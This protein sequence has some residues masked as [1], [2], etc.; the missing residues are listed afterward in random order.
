MLNLLVVNSMRSHS[1][2]A[3]SI[4]LS[5]YILA[6]TFMFVSYPRG[7]AIIGPLL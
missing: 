2:F 3:W 7:I 1:T 6:Y 5:V 4:V